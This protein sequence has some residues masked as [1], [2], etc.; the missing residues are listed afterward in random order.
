[1]GMGK[2]TTNTIALEPPWWR[3]EN[4]TE[5][6]S[7]PNKPAHC[8]VCRSENIELVIDVDPALRSRATQ[9]DSKEGK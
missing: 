2:T 8:P 9:A 6:R 4:G 1:M 5:F 7:G 3:C